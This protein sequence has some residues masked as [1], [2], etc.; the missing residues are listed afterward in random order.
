MQ[1]ALGELQPDLPDRLARYV[2]LGEDEEV[3]AVLAGIPATGAR[4]C[5]P[6]AF[7]YLFELRSQSSRPP[8]WDMLLDH[9]VDVPTEVVLRLARALG[10]LASLVGRQ[11]AARLP[12]NLAQIR[13]SGRPWEVHSGWKSSCWPGCPRLPAVTRAAPTARAG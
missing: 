3:L 13:R 7:P 8:A 1:T 5:S 12:A 9:A 10:A 11:A 6:T 2:E 4:P